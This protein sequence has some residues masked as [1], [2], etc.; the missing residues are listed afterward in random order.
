M[1]I[2]LRVRFPD[3]SLTKFQAFLMTAGEAGLSNVRR[4]SLMRLSSAW[5]NVA[6]KLFLADW[7]F[8]DDARR[9]A[10]RA[11]TTGSVSTD[12]GGGRSLEERLRTYPVSNQY[13]CG[14]ILFCWWEII[15]TRCNSV[16]DLRCNHRISC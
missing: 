2:A 4:V 10:L 5:L 9:V 16:V 8:L 13:K 14:V 1:K 6:R 3:R 15:E 11:V 7:M 12:F